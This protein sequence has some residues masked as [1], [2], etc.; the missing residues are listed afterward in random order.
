MATNKKHQCWLPHCSLETKNLNTDLHIDWFRNY[1]FME[2]HYG[3]GLGQDFGLVSNA[4]VSGS[5]RKGPTANIDD[6]IGE[7]VTAMKTFDEFYQKVIESCAPSSSSILVLPSVH[8]TKSLANVNQSFVRNVTSSSSSSGS[9]ATTSKMDGQEQQSKVGK[10]LLTEAQRIEIELQMRTLKK[11]DSQ[12][13]DKKSFSKTVTSHAFTSSTALY[14]YK[15]SHIIFNEMCMILQ[16]RTFDISNDCSTKHINSS[17]GRESNR[18]CVTGT[19]REIEMDAYDSKNPDHLLVYDIAFGLAGSSNNGSNTGHMTINENN[20]MRALWFHVQ[21]GDVHECTLQERMNYKKTSRKLEKL[22]KIQ[23]V[24]VAAAAS[25]ATTNLSNIDCYCRHNHANVVAALKSFD[26]NQ[27][28]YQNGFIE[29]PIIMNLPMDRDLF[30]LTTE[31][32]KHRLAALKGYG[33]VKYENEELLRIQQK[34]VSLKS[35]IQKICF[36]P[37]NN[38]REV[39]DANTSVPKVDEQYKVPFHAPLKNDFFLEAKEE[40]HFQDKVWESFI[41]SVSCYV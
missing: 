5:C 20:R 7:A 21:E 18:S 2:T 19:V 27:E 23:D 35:H 4:T 17:S 13:G 6:G 3:H 1:S 34:F 8:Y 26:I 40:F 32:L 24:K 14:K 29:K 16:T 37:I 10:T 28:I 22:K 30:S 38:G 15:P 41:V 39:V 31:V 12:M 33:T 36:W 25:R 11:D 9:I